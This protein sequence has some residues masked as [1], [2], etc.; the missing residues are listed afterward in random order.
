MVF[1]FVV[2]AAAGFLLTAA[3]TWTG[4][5]PPAGAPL[6]ALAALWLAGRA[7]MFL[8]GA[9]PLAG[10][11]RRHHFCQRWRSRS[12]ADLPQTAAEL[13]LSGRL[14][15]RA[16]ERGAHLTRSGSRPAWRP[17]VFTS[18]SISRSC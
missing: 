11:A 10:R 4:S 14:G 7:A 17:S 9:I 8:S 6:A 15:A 16:L 12:A 2:A 13:Q 1:G 5:R 18:A 3:P